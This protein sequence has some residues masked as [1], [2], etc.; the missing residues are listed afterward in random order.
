MCVGLIVAVVYK[1]FENRF[2]SVISYVLK[3]K[4]NVDISNKKSL[5]GPPSRTISTLLGAN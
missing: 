3:I 1:Y 2:V 5:V 4:G